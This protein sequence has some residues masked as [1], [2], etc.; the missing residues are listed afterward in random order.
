MRGMRHEVNGRM[1]SDGSE[2]PKDSVGGDERM[3]AET[4]PS[5]D[6]QRHHSWVELPTD[7]DMRDLV[8]K[9]LVFPLKIVRV[10][11]QSRLLLAMRD[12][13][14]QEAIQEVEF[15]SGL[16]VIPVL[17]SEL[18]IRWLVHRHLYG[19][20][21]TPTP[22]FRTRIETDGLFENLVRPEVSSQNSL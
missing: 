9:F 12:C 2:F 19:R 14:H 4:I 20:S 7:F 16:K 5:F 6:L 1:I 13:F 3:T 17:A 18:D 11:N 10:D 22:S 21:L 8:R 15:R